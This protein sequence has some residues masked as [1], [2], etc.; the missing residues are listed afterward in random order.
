MI[1]VQ[2][3]AGARELLMQQF[4]VKRVPIVAKGGKF[5]FAHI[6]ETIAEFIG[7][8]GPGQ[9]RLPPAEL[10][11]KWMH[12]LRAARRYVTQ[13][14]DEQLNQ[15]ATP[16]RV[17]TVRLLEHHV[18]NIVDS[19]IECL[20]TGAKSLSDLTNREDIGDMYSSAEEMARYGGDA[21]ARIEKWWSELADKSLQ[22][23]SPATDY[24]PGFSLH[25]MLE[26]SV[27]HSTQHTRQVA[28]VL[29]RLGIE[30]DGKL[31]PEDLAGLPLPE[32]IWE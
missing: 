10:F 15:R 5:V 25:Q 23:L 32:R 6:L 27:W 20:A 18:F 22:G 31:T 7:Q 3:D 13:M 19:H 21:I 4:G 28:A 26:L 2:N 24:G 30:P 14:P 29:E 1:D 17:R 8:Q 11:N 9:V 12:I 16:N